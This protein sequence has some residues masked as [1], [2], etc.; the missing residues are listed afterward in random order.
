MY[1][2]TATITMLHCSWMFP[3][4]NMNHNTRWICTNGK[5]ISKRS[6]LVMKNMKKM[7]KIL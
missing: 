3:V 7:Y 1:A 4:Y 2:V 5:K 6:P